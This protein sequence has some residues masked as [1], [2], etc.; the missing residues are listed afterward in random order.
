MSL[1]TERYGRQDPLTIEDD[2]IRHLMCAA[3][4]DS[5]Q[6]RGEMAR[7]NLKAADRIRLQ[8]DEIAKLTR[9]RNELAA[10][11]LILRKANIG[12]VKAMEDES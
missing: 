8:Q 4:G 9:E 12:M 11:A 2:D 7:R 3:Q 6:G 1:V 10:F 5:R